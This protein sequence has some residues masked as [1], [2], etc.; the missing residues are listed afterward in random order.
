MDALHA[1]VACNDGLGKQKAALQGFWR[2]YR[3]ERYIENGV[4]KWEYPNKG[5]IEM[6]R[7]C[8]VPEH[9]TVI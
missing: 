6:K 1:L 8:K 2:A 3:G 9:A 5:T 7:I 4:Y